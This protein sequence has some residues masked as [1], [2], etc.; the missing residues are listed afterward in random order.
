MQ[1]HLH[2]RPDWLL[3]TT[4]LVSMS[5]TAGCTRQ[6]HV[7]KEMTWECAPEHYMS[8]YPEAQPVRFRFVEDPR[9]EEVVSGKGLCDQLRI[10]G[11]R[12][13]AVEYETWGSSYRGLIGFR[14]VSVDGK[15]IVDVGGWGSSGAHGQGG[16]HPLE[17][18]YKSNSR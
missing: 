13:V 4:L 12:V 7:T 10:S 8:Q 6:V 15:P 1:L 17:K 11:K 3:T 5:A 9:F 16:P 14:E 2:Q 18:L